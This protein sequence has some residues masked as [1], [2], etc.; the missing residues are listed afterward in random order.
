MRSAKETIL[1]AST[2]SADSYILAMLSNNLLGTKFKVV[3]G[4]AGATEVSLAV[5]NGEVQGEAGKDWT[6]LTSTKPQWIRDKLI[7]ILVQMGMKA[8][9]DLKGVPM[10]IE[11]AKT[12]EDRQVMEVVFAKYRHVAA[13]LHGARRTAGAARAIA[14]RLRRD[15]ERSGR[16]RGGQEARHGSEPG[17]RRGGREAGDEDDGD[18][19]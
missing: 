3:H 16:D 9:P 14:A 19:G 12:P 2:P 8:H 18:A 5:E 10:A 17:A 7:N 15:A 4:Y 11:L 13:V 1:G 6:T